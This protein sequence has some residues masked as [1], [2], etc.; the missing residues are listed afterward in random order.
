MLLLRFVLRTRPDGHNTTAPDSLAQSSSLPTRTNVFEEWALMCSHSSMRL[1]DRYGAKPSAYRSTWICAR[2]D[3]TCS[4]IESAG[5]RGHVQ[6][7]R[8]MRARINT[9]SPIERP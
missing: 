4:G 6:A 5:V 8:R 7:E 9:S 3:S 2:S 1:T